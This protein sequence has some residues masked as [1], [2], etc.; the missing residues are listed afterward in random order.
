MYNLK[1]K[2]KIMG[3]QYVGPEVDV[4]SLGVVLYS[5]LAGAFPFENVSAILAGNFKDCE[6]ASKGKK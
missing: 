4:W 3:R 5:M 6:K 1:K 2:N